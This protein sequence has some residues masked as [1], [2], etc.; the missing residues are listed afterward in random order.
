MEKSQGSGEAT[1]SMGKVPTT[2]ADPCMLMHESLLI[3]SIFWQ[4][5]KGYDFGSSY[6]KGLSGDV[7]FVNAITNCICYDDSMECEI[8]AIFALHA[9]FYDVEAQ[10]YLMKSD[11]IDEQ[12]PFQDV[13]H[14]VFF[15]HSTESGQDASSA[16]EDT[17]LIDLGGAGQPSSL[18]RRPLPPV[19]WLLSFPPLS[20]DSASFWRGP[21]AWAL[22]E[23]SRILF[24]E[25]YTDDCLM[26]E[27]NSG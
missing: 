15:A 2:F 26:W 27:Q 14:E 11:Q 24:P 4:E 6:L 18:S 9:E 17:Q 5:E 1:Q 13:F 25:R 23:S 12:K 8:D 22:H 19:A 20:L 10:R 21:A 16:M 3:S 7:Q